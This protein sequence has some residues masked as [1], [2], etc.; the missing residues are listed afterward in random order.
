MPTTVKTNG[1]IIRI[2]DTPGK[3]KLLTL[4]T[5]TG[6]VTAFITPKRNAGK[7][8]Y[9]FDLFTYGEIVLYKTDS[10]NYLVNSITPTEVFYSLREDIVRLS[11]ASY[12]ANL[13]VH[14]AADEETDSGQLL[15]FLLS[16][17]SRLSKGGNVKKIKPV[18]ELKITQALG[19][20]PCLEADRKSLSYYF[21]IDDGRLYASD[22]SKGVLVS[23]D[24][25]LCIYKILNAEA[26]KAFEFTV[27]DE[28]IDLLYAVTQQY[29]LYHLERSFDSLEFLNGVL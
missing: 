29:L 21:D 23:R 19:F 14:A 1:I 9:T 20:S 25:I 12:L 6:L 15:S 7:K 10:G 8:S 17:V 5:E 27:S 28:E 22:S 4:L 16:A 2:K 18:F 11:A 13:A 24:L 26:E 3:D